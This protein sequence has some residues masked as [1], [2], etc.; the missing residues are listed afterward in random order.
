MNITKINKKII[1]DFT[2][3]IEIIQSLMNGKD[4][5]INN[6]FLDGTIRLKIRQLKNDIR[7]VREN[8]FY[9]IDLIEK[10]DIQND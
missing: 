10:R 7:D 8:L 2:N 6:Q 4:E 1:T 3:E 9:L 5:Y